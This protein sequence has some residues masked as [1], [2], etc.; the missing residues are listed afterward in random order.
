MSD[1]PRPTSEDSSPTVPPGGDDASSRAAVHAWLGGMLPPGPRVGPG[2]GRWH[3]AGQE[4]FASRD[5]HAGWWTSFRLRPRLKNSLCGTIP[6]ATRWIDCLLLPDNSTLSGKYELFRYPASFLEA[7]AVR[8]VRYFRATPQ[9]SGH[10]KRF[11]RRPTRRAA[12]V[13][14]GKKAGAPVKTGKE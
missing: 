2:D 3:R 5:R 7:A 8:P 6:L 10:P 12:G 9:L 13:G 1:V 11:V 4:A 14:Q